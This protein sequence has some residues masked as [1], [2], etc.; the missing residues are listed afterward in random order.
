MIEES[1][2]IECQVCGDNGSNC[3][4]CQECEN[5]SDKCTCNNI[6]EEE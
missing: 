6:S 3:G 1:L 4:C 5:T 2:V